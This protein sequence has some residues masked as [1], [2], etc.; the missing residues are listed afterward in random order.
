MRDERRNKHRRNLSTSSCGVGVPPA[1]L[2]RR[3]LSF[4]EVGVP[5]GQPECLFAPELLGKSRTLTALREAAQTLAETDL[6]VLI[7]G[8]PGTGK[9]LL[10]RGLHVASGR[11]GEY[12][13]VNVASLSRELI[14]SELFGYVKGAFTNA[15]SDRQGLVALAEK[16]TLFLDEIGELPLDQQ[17]KLLRF[18]QENKIRPV[19]GGAERLID[20]RVLAATNQNLLE[21]VRAGKFR[22]DLYDRLA[23][24]RL[25]MPP[26]RLREDDIVMLAQNFL[27]EFR[28][29]NPA[30]VLTR[31]AISIIR[32]HAWPGNVREL[33]RVMRALA[34]HGKTIEIEGREV[35]EYLECYH[36]EV[37]RPEVDIGKLLES[38]GAASTEE[39]AARAQVSPSTVLRVLLPLRRSG[40]V[41]MRRVGKGNVFY[42][43]GHSATAGG[44][45][46]PEPLPLG[47]PSDDIQLSTQE[48]DPLR[49]QALALAMQGEVSRMALVNAAH[50][51]PRTALRVLSGLVVDGKLLPVGQ[52]RALRYKIILPC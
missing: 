14:D 44:I 20:V 34:L 28:R 49:A 42:W 25:E 6:T 31:S 17:P 39:L 27:E 1:R 37:A 22:R 7:T 43:T 30:R 45:Y 23:E 26:L 24:T 32:E 46:M 33:Q 51:S 16:G 40:K 10:A 21:A 15:Q 9:E 29:S 8:E 4:V 12:V 38:V 50:I 5:E 18:L 41:S 3:D 48:T 2:P 47:R 11:S 52:G 19:G 36:H 35:K 13:A